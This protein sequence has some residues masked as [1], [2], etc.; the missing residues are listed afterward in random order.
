MC[1]MV[2]SDS[3]STRPIHPLVSIWPKLL[4]DSICDG[5]TQQNFLMHWIVY[6]VYYLGC[7][8]VNKNA[9]FAEWSI[10]KRDVTTFRY[11]CLRHFLPWNPLFIFRYRCCDGHFPALVSTY[12]LNVR[13]ALLWFLL[14]I[15]L[16]TLVRLI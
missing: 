10:T 5:W 8:D 12:F 14:L 2:T 7:L 4:K 9:P 15:V 11:C 6:S 3:Q 16:S 13:L 1:Q